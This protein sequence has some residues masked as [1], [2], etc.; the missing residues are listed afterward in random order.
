MMLKI[1][2]LDENLK[3]YGQ[4]DCRMSIDTDYSCKTVFSRIRSGWKIH[5]NFVWYKTMQE[6]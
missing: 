6:T 4:T 3:N 5:L 2:I 1:M